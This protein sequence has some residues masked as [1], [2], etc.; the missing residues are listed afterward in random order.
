MDQM[1]EAEME[2]LLGE[3]AS[4]GRDGEAALKDLPDTI[5]SYG[6]YTD[7]ELQQF[8]EAGA[9]ADPAFV[10]LELRMNANLRSLVKFS[11]EMLKQQLRTNVLLAQIMEKL[12]R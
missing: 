1:T 8:V 12:G 9:H 3:I 11:R 5:R 10:E 7:R 4:V 2:Q 6:K